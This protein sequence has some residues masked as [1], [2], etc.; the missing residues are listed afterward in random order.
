[1]SAHGRP[2]SRKPRPSR[3]VPPHVIDE[4]RAWDEYKRKTTPEQRERIATLLQG[5]DPELNERQLRL[6]AARELPLFAPMLGGGTCCHCGGKL[7][8]SGDDFE[9]TLGGR[10]MCR[11]PECHAADERWRA[12]GGVG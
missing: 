2:R 8:L 6:T 3:T 1:M 5:R 12:E 4:R 10:L 9:W 7:D 11:R